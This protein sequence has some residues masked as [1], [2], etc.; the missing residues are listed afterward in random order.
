MHKR[1]RGQ[2]SN[3]LHM[4]TATLD[5]HVSFAQAL[6][7]AA[8]SCAYKLLTDKPAV[9]GQKSNMAAAA[10]YVLLLHL[11]KAGTKKE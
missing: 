9:H 1:I 7:N 10:Q 3:G 8:T 6:A 4:M 5:T 11:A 2:R